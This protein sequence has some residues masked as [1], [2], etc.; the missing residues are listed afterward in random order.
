MSWRITLARK[1][2]GYTQTS[3]EVRAKLRPD[4]ADS[5]MLASQVIAVHFQT[6][7]ADDLTTALYNYLYRIFGKTF[8]I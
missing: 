2:V 4:Y 1:G 6:V 3:A 8:Y 5:L 7:V